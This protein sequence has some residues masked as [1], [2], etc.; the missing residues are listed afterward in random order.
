MKIKILR[1][2][3]SGSES[4]LVPYTGQ[5]LWNHLVNQQ[6]QNKH[7][8]SSQSLESGNNSWFYQSF[9]VWCLLNSLDQKK[10]LWDFHLYRACIR[11]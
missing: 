10:R 11:K 3:H 9:P 6:R 2:L 1:Q 7:F 8:H 4:T 5:P